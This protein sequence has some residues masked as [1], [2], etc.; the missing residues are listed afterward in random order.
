MWGIF[1]N[2]KDKLLRKQ[3][4]L[5]GL[6]NKPA[7]YNNTEYLFAYIYQDKCGGHHHTNVR[8]YP[9]YTELN[10]VIV[11]NLERSVTPEIIYH[12]LSHET[13]HLVLCGIL[14][15]QYGFIEKVIDGWM[16]R[17]EIQ[18]FDTDLKLMEVEKCLM[19]KQ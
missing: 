1:R 15:K 8:Y 16:L 19:K 2:K 7:V 17:K 14:T 6:Y 4:R 10:S 13:L 11:L 18:R 9:N 12:I 5:W 3:N